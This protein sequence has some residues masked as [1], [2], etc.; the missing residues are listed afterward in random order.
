MAQL[1]RFDFQSEADPLQWMNK[2]AV[3]KYNVKEVGGLEITPVST[4]NTLR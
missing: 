2:P 4:Q 1:Q 3:L